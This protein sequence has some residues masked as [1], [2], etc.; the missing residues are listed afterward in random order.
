MPRGISYYAEGRT[1]SVFGAEGEEVGNGLWVQNTGP[2]G[3]IEED[4]PESDALDELHTRL[5][6]MLDAE[7]G[8]QI[9]Q[10]RLGRREAVHLFLER[11]LRPEHFKRAYEE[12]GC[13]IIP[14][15]RIP[16]SKIGG[17]WVIV[18]ICISKEKHGIVFLDNEGQILKVPH[19]SRFEEDMPPDFEESEELVADDG[20][21]D[22]ALISGEDDELDMPADP[23]EIAVAA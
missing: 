10:I 7:I 1:I 11:L 12:N 2:Y 18:G 16:Y 13:I 9:A 21:P 4:V 20:S 22:L 8:E 6:K 14:E 15:V 5:N 17:L 3:G 19:G 23:E